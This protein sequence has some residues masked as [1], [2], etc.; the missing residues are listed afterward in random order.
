MVA[1]VVP[2]NPASHARTMPSNQIHAL[3]V[4]FLTSRGTDPANHQRP[5]TC[6]PPIFN[7]VPRFQNR[8][9]DRPIS[10]LSAWRGA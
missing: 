7:D 10:R 1:L 4:A 6:E 9:S 2:E 3:P 8:Q 5:P